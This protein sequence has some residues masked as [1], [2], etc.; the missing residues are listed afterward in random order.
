MTEGLF[1]SKRTVVLWTS[2]TSNFQ[3]DV[4]FPTILLWDAH[5]VYTGI[6]G[7]RVQKG[8]LLAEWLL[9]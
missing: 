6:H 2:R 5:S 8:G 3:L 1:V 9:A 7:L 4:F